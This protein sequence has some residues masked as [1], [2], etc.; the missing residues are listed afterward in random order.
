MNQFTNKDRYVHELFNSIAADYDRM[1]LLMTWGMLPRW[2]SFMLNKTGLKEGGH[3]LDVCCGTG[4]LAFK[5]AKLVGKTGNISGL[6]FSENMLAVA[7]EKLAVS[8][9]KNI[10]FVQGDALELPFE[11]NSFDAATNGFALRNVTDI[12]KAIREMARVVKPGGKVVCL[13]VSRPLNPLLRLGFNIY[14]FKIVPII[15]RIVDKGK[16]IDDKYPAYT[17]LPESLKAF[18]D[19]EKLKAIFWAA[20]L[21]QV[22]YFGLGAGAVTV[23]VGTKGKLNNV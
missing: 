16:A 13:E 3:G 9:A 2:Q 10:N 11:D 23:H 1:N 12:P 4:E 21:V 18:P 7:K 5:M 6:D 17:W 19:Q 20:G 14:F 8:D 15:G 22:Q